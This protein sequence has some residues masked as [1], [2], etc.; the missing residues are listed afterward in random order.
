MPPQHICKNHASLI[1]LQLYHIG[2][3]M[4]PSP[5]NE[6]TSLYKLGIKVL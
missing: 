3:L 4:I 6:I 1:I 2:Q 5:D